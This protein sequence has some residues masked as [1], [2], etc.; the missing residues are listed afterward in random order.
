MAFN[1]NPLPREE[2]EMAYNR[3]VVKGRWFETVDGD[4]VP[5]SSSEAR[6]LKYTDGEEIPLSEARAA[7]LVPVVKEAPKAAQKDATGRGAQ[8]K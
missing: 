3:F 6:F 2:T 4:V 7:G 5:E 1:L 8:N